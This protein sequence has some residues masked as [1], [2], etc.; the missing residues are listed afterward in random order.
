MLCFLAF[1]P[2]AGSAMRALQAAAVLCPHCSCCSDHDGPKP[3]DTK[4]TRI[5]GVQVGEGGGGGAEPAWGIQV[6]GPWGHCACEA[7]AVSVQHCTLWVCR[8]GQCCV[9]RRPTAA[10]VGPLLGCVRVADSDELLV[11]LQEGVLV[12]LSRFLTSRRCQGHQ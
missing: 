7:L 9:Q 6:A 11:P 10:S 1:L 4:L 5:G 8:P 3:R 2:T 12:G